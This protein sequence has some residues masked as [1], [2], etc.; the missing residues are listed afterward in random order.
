MTTTQ[1]PKPNAIARRYD[2]L[3]AVCDATRQYDPEVG[4]TVWFKTLEDQ[5]ALAA[6]IRALAPL[7]R[8]AR[9]TEAIEA[10]AV[11]VETADAARFQ[12]AFDQFGVWAAYAAE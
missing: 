10:W 12:W 6:D 4:A 3:S 2:A 9:W 7:G 1:N 5:D 11:Q 8:T